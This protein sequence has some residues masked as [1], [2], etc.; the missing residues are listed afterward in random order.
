MLIQKNSLLC[1]LKK[2]AT[3][4]NNR[5]KKEIDIDIDKDNLT[6]FHAP[7]NKMVKSMAILLI[8]AHQKLFCP[9]YSARLNIIKKIRN[10]HSEDLKEAQEEKKTPSGEILSQIDIFRQNLMDPEDAGFASEKK[11]YNA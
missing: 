11:R 3:E 4:I 7:R 9:I 10:E 2:S 6:T 5:I 1:L 8:S